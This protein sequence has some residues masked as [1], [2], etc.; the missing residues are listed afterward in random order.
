MDT[1]ANYAGNASSP[2]NVEEA[3]TLR[4]TAFAADPFGQ[5]ASPAH[6]QLARRAAGDISDCMMLL[7]EYKFIDVEPPVLQM[8]QQ[9]VNELANGIFEALDNRPRPVK[10]IHSVLFPSELYVA[11]QVGE[12]VS[13]G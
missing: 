9:R 8:L 7:A 4:A 2:A 3:S 11:D 5:G 12:E 10:E 1:S 13:H 6:L